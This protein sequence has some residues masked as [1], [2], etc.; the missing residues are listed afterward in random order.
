MTVTTTTLKR[1]ISYA[2]KQLFSESFITSMVWC[3]V[4]RTNILCNI[5]VYYQ[6]VTM[7][8]TCYI[9]SDKVPR[10]ITMLQHHKSLSEE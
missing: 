4:K 7:T 8:I 3:L 9:D 1:H 10:I 5:T 6:L 2:L